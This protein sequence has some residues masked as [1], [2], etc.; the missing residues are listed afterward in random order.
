ML[1]G[2]VLLFL[3]Y[4]GYLYTH[5]PHKVVQKDKKVSKGKLLWQDYNC[6]ACHQVYGLGGFLGPDLTNEYSLRGPVFIRTMLQNGTAVMPQ[7]NMTEEE[8]DDISSYL[9]DVDASG[10]A[11]PRTF[12]I[13]EDGTISQ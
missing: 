2:G 6:N 4:S 11:D 12:R 8:I 5:L 7:F 10:K 3:I 9:K 1:S 13:H